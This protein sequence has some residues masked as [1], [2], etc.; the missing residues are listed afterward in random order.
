M[1][2]KQRFKNKLIQ[3]FKVGGTDKELLILGE[4]NALEDKVDYSIQEF[5]TELTQTVDKIDS[6]IKTLSDPLRG[7]D[8]IKIKGAKGDKPTKED[9]LGLIIP[10]IPSVK[11]GE[12]Y[13]LTEQDKK[14]IANSIDVPIV[15]KVIEKTE[16]IKEQ[17]IVTEVTNEIV[18]EVA[19]TDK[20][21]VIRDKL[22]T[23]TGDERLDAKS[24]KGLEKGVTQ[25][26]LD[27]AV[28]ILDSRTSFLINKVT[29][30][31]TQ[32]N[33]IPNPNSIAVITDSAGA[34][35]DATRGNQFTWSATSDRT[36]G[37]TIGA[38]TGQKIIIYF[39]ASGGARTLTL[40]T[41][42]TGDFAY[43]SD[44][45][46]LTQTASGKTDAIGCVYNT[47]VANKWAVLA[48][49]KGF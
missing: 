19:V 15:E 39:T 25:D 12:D 11:N 35:I 18:K 21:E 4:V 22:E 37:T 45:T 30:V 27:R 32:V 38:T 17:P 44:I 16:V 14:D 43:G 28:S 26:T 3:L 7:V 9:L 31:Q 46:G 10:L 20:P 2:K 13:V 6:K 47:A 24:I 33:N 49:T 36:A 1:D 8:Q 29:N 5:R 41:S 34:V 23:L 48:Y 40:P 42:T